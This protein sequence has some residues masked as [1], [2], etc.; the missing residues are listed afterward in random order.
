MVTITSKTIK[1]IM[2]GDPVSY[3][4]A[5]KILF[6][7][8][9]NMQI[10]GSHHIFRKKKYTKNV[11]IKKRSKLLNYQVKLIREVLKDHGYKET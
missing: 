11:S 4:E 6:H 3:K 8:G 5:E 2:A 10:S 9:F 1:K 7:L